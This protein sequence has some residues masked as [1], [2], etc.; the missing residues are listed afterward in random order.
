MKTVQ[1]WWCGV[2]LVAFVAAGPGCG[3]GADVPPTQDGPMETPDAGA[4]AQDAGAAGSRDGGG[5]SGQDAGETPAGDAGT[6]GQD[7]GTPQAVDAGTEDAGLSLL[8]A[9]SGA[10]GCASAPALT[11]G[12]WKVD[13]AGA[14]GDVSQWEG[15]CGVASTA[16]GPDR[17][18][19]VEVPAGHL[20]RAS[21]LAGSFSGARL[22]LLRDCAA[23]TSSCERLGNARVAW[24]NTSA[25]PQ[26]VVLAV[27]GLLAAQQG[28]A[29]VKLD[30]E[31]LAQQPAG[32][33]CAGAVAL[34]LPGNVSGNTAGRDNL[35][36]GY[37]GAG[38]VCNR[39]G[40]FP[41]LGGGGD[42]SYAVQVP[43]GKTLS[44][45][46][47]TSGGWDV[48]VAILDGCGPAATTCAAWSDPGTAQVT[49][50]SGAPRTYF[51]VVDGF[52]PHSSGAYTLG[53]SVN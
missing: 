50:T 28:V 29:G 48:V 8:P 30:L 6:A 37:V 38:G 34:G 7:A 23:P 51:V 3:G 27:D 39:Y 13:T 18:F 19:T 17:F 53:A 33:T 26:Q 43:A 31:P 25:S 24:A 9:A 35:V 44:V 46:A 20:L 47:T 11:A 4:A 16:S 12:S 22:V 1:A 2:A 42:V 32:A 36:D 49:N 5:P 15:T 45:S 21:L 41:G 14:A 40:N 10:D 52:H